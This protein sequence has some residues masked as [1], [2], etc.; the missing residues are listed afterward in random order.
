M[1]MMRFG[2][3]AGRERFLEEGGISRTGVGMDLRPPARLATLIFSASWRA[4]GSR[5]PA[6]AFFGLGTKS[7]AP[8]ARALKV[9]YAPSF[10]CVLKTI[11]GSGA[12][13]M[14]M[15]RVS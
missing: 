14:I 1:A 15:R 9:E 8:R 2:G 7:M 4:T 10:E 5:L 12:P 11:T 6:A 13:R 3:T